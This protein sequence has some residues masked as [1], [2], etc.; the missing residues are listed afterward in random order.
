MH[1]HCIKIRYS[2]EPRDFCLLLK[3]WVKV[4]IAKSNKNGQKR[5]DSAQTS[6]TDA[7][8]TTSKRA[9]QKT[10]EATGDLIANKITDKVTC[11]SKGLH[12]KKSSTELH[13]KE[14]QNDETEA[15]EKRRIHIS[16]RE[17]TN[18]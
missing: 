16:R 10:A 7:R 3:T 4:F 9:I 14:L 8:K 18:Y 12:S 2:I 5:L 1:F 17:A 6:S 15:P 11:V 13:S